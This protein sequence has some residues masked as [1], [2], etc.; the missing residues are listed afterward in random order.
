MNDLEIA[1]DEERKKKES[2]SEQLREQALIVDKER[3][4]KEDLQ[5]TLIDKDAL[6][7]EELTQLQAANRDMNTRLSEKMEREKELEKQLV[8]EQKDKEGLQSTLNLLAHNHSNN[9][10]NYALKEEELNQLQ[11]ANRDLSVQL[12]EKLEREQTLLRQLNEEQKTKEDLQS[13]LTQLSHDHSINDNNNALKIEELTQLQESNR[14]LSIKLSEQIEREQDL[15]RQLDEE[16]KEKEDLQSTLELLCNSKNDVNAMKEEELT[17]LQAVNKELRER[18]Q[19]LERQLVEERHTHQELYQQLAEEQK[20]KANSTVSDIQQQL[21][22]QVVRFKQEQEAKQSL[23]EQLKEEKDAAQQLEDKLQQLLSDQEIMR[24]TLSEQL[25]KQTSML[26]Q[27]LIEKS[28]LEKEL[29]EQC[30]L[31]QQSQEK[32]ETIV[33]YQ[34]AEAIGEASNR[35]EINNDDDNSNRNVDQLN[36]E[37]EENR[38]HEQALYQWETLFEKE[39]A[40]KLQL[41]EELTVVQH[42]QEHEKMDFQAKAMK[43]EEQVQN[44]LQQ[45]QE[46]QYQQP[47]E[48]HLDGDVKVDARKDLDR[49]SDV[50]KELENF[51]EKYNS[52]EELLNLERQEHE[53]VYEQY[54]A[55]LQ[56]REETVALDKNIESE[57]ELKGTK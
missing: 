31:Y 40:F 6:R 52:L 57:K 1:L 49:D 45:L 23:Q 24:A 38:I 5:A 36:H 44:L 14:D 29:E 15:E 22:D 17:E 47:E 41:E 13:T 12:S 39:R 48:S 20:E 2:I 50:I 35:T 56:E 11:A 42:Q 18:K 53:K 51:K 4:E 9:D 25:D 3:R 7:A 37:R 21:N 46:Q 10:N 55:V 32:Y 26:K 19:E 33:H 27:E 54:V 16:R 43:L 8:E 30:L 34:K 28:I